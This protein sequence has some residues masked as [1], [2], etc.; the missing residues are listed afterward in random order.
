MRA[1]LQRTT[2]SDR[3]QLLIEDLLGARCE[4]RDVEGEPGVRFKQPPQPLALEHAEH[5]VRERLD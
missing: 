3:Q 4:P 2:A 1:A 5:Y